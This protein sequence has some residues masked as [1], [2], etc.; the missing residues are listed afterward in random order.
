MIQIIHIDINFHCFQTFTTF[1]I[2]LT[3]IMTALHYDNTVI[4]IKSSIDKVNYLKYFLY[5][6]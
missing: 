2:L 5:D 4:K 6:K 1:I 3:L